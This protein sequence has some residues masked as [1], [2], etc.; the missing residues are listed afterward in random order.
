MVIKHEICDA[1]CFE[2]R[3]N[4]MRI[5]IILIPLF[6]GQKANIDV[7]ITQVSFLNTGN[8]VEERMKLISESPLNI[9]ARFCLCVMCV[10]P[11]ESTRLCCQKRH[12]C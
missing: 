10:M 7:F 11:R 12:L 4:Y 8:L 5:C 6:E 1:C 9:I 2:Y 3:K